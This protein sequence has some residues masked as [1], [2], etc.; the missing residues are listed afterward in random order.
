MLE[1]GSL[2]VCLT[3]PYPS[4]ISDVARPAICTESLDLVSNAFMP[5][6]GDNE[7]FVPICFP[8]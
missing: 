8:K 2:N 3:I 7:S 6:G 5:G 1:I 4:T